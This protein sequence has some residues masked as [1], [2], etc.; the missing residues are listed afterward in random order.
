MENIEVKMLTDALQQTPWFREPTGAEIDGACFMADTQFNFLN[1]AKQAER[2]NEARMWLRAWKAQA[3]L[4][5]LEAKPL[6]YKR[7]D[8]KR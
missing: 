2:R 5:H 7:R 8:K 4:E 6:V 3:R 1:P